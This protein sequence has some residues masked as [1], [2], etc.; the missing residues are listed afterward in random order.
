MHCFDQDFLL[1]CH[2][3]EKGGRTG[4]ETLRRLFAYIGQMQ[5]LTYYIWKAVLLVSI[6][7]LLGALF[8]LYRVESGAVGLYEFYR[9]AAELSELPKAFILMGLFLTLFSEEGRK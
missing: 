1:H 8:F 6:L 5:P 3:R 9:C 7:S 2:Q 4:L